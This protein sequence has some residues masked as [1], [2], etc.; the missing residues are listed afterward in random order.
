MTNDEIIN[1][2]R[3]N[4]HT[5]AITF[6]Y[7]EFPK[8][9]AL[10]LKSGCNE[11]LATEI[12][13]DSL[14]LFIEKVKDPGFELTSKATTYLYGINRFMVKN[15][16]KKQYRSVEL[17]W[18]D[19]LILSAEDL[20]YSDEKEEELKQLESILASISDRCQTIFR[21]FYFEKESMDSIA[22]KL[23]FSSTN[24]A[25]TQK[26]KCLQRAHQIAQEM[27]HTTKSAS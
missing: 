13:N 24:S 3:N 4:D 26:Y 17:E 7:K 16:L 14:L 11:V 9:K 1:S 19:T 15:E 6:L 10:I 21:L 5:K 20:H 18:K 23:G 27:S 2:I 8:V 25:K 22:E 12:F